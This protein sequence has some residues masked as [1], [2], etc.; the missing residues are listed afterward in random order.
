LLVGAAGGELDGRGGKRRREKDGLV[1]H[2][3]VGVGVGGSDTVDGQFDYPGGDLTVEQ[4]E[5]A[6][7]PQSQRKAVTA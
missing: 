7:H 2:D 4:H 5:G 1:P 3:Q 6:G